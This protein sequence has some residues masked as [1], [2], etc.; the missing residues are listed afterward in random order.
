MEFVFIFCVR[1][2]ETVPG[3]N[4]VIPA[5]AADSSRMAGHAAQTLLVVNIP[6]LRKQKCTIKNNRKQFFERHVSL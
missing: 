4:V 6:Q 3:K 1:D 5:Q 2:E